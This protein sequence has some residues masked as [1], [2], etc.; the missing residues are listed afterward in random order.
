MA[1]TI[2]L[3]P[4]FVLDPEPDQGSNN[5]SNGTGLPP[6]FVIDPPEEENKGFF[7]Q[8]QAPPQ[9]KSLIGQGAD[10]AVRLAK[11]MT[12]GALPTSIKDVK[13]ILDPRMGRFGVS[14][15]LEEEGAIV[16]KAA[17][18]AAPLAGKAIKQTV[19]DRHPLL[20]AMSPKAAELLG[21]AEGE[22]TE[23]AI[24]LYS[25]VF[26]PSA[27]QEALG[28]QAI[29]PAIS[30][31]LGYLGVKSHDFAVALAR[32]T[33][34]YTKRFFK[35]PGS[36]DR[37]NKVAQE[38]L[39]QKVI[40]SNAQTML[41]R[42]QALSDQAG[43]K[44]GSIL[45]KLDDAGIQAVDSD[46]IVNTIVQQ[47]DSGKTGGVYT[48]R[49][50]VI[51]EV[52]DTVNA[53]G[54][55]KLSFN[56]A[57][58]LKNTLKDVADLGVESDA[59]RA[60]M[61]KRAYGIVRNKIDDGVELAESFLG[62]K[63]SKIFREY[64]N[65]KAIYGKAKEATK[66][67]VNK[68]SSELG[69]NVVGLRET[70]VGAEALGHLATGNQAKAA[71]AIKTGAVA[72]G[73][74]TG[75]KIQAIVSKMANGLSR[76]L[77]K[78][79]P[80]HRQGVVRTLINT[81]VLGEARKYYN[82]FK[83]AG[84]PLPKDFIIDEEPSIPAKVEKKSTYVQGL[85]SFVKGDL[86]NAEKIWK[87]ALKENPKNIEARRGLNR[88]D[89]E[90]SGPSNENVDKKSKAAYRD[91]LQAYLDKDIKNAKRLWTQALEI[92]SNNREA[93]RGLERLK[94]QGVA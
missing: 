60:N 50:K 89:K 34:G 75:G 29:N 4:G 62:P 33:L 17:Q 30:S 44:I 45:T 80:Y 90:R 16:E 79:R 81:G 71:Q 76:F 36:F 13:Q 32:R 55:G 53:H 58:E 57:Q 46:D 48:N 21:K 51:Q 69:N 88:L 18:G 93:R 15:F 24:D 2:N 67:L 20:T 25:P 47:L 59:F 68:L 43:K 42:A 82:E 64:V 92:D 54:G 9:P 37:A 7:S 8:V 35:T 70:I 6:G 72:V 65:N 73:L 66:A 52:V 19:K 77:R 1:T 40:S 26:R 63:E 85:E 12:T 61:F 39:K 83:K 28:A 87:Q 22:L 41:D 56:S 74:K 3:P 94:R 14:K 11:S 38:M 31:T 78:V 49:R 23:F 84:V 5:K 10:A 86:I 91:G 27:W